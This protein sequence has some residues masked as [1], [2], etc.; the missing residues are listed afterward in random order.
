MS[1]FVDMKNI[2]KKRIVTR[3][4]IRELKWVWKK[5]TA[6]P[7]W[8]WINVLMIR[9]RIDV[10]AQ[11]TRHKRKKKSF[12]FR[13]TLAAQP[14]FYSFQFHVLWTKL[15]HFFFV[16]LGLYVALPPHWQLALWLCAF[17]PRDSLWLCE[18][19]SFLI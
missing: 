15:E 2:L 9:N 17:C 6:T 11:E 13:F 16:A 12:H 19:D 5:K 7:L 10:V 18:S 4:N 1:I 3:W 14:F 8:R